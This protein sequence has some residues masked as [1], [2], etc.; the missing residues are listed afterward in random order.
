MGPETD[1]GTTQAIQNLP[2]V[3]SSGKIIPVSSLARVQVTTGPTAI[4]HRERQRAIT[5]RVRPDN[6][7]ALGDAINIVRDKVLTQVTGEGLPPGIRFQLTGTA[8]EL[9]ATAAELKWD[10]ILALAIVFLLMAVLFESF[11]Y[12]LIIVFSVPLAAAG[13][14]LGLTIL[15]L[16]DSEQR[17]DMLT[18]LGFV[19]LIGIVV[20]NAILIVHQALHHYRE[21]KMECQEAVMEATRNRI[22]PI[23]MSTLTS[24]FGMLPLVLFPGAGSEIY[25]GLGSVVVG[26]LSFS[27]ILTLAIVPPLLSIVMQTVEKARINRTKNKIT[28]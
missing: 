23:F 4:W 5:V 3:V 2:V 25:R 28:S 22:R 11:V 13:G 15:R 14:V 20:N 9:D 7:I 18:I 17:L 8:K 21:E 27:A 1:V 16:F 26:G 6:D 24:V 10:L 19:I 12:P